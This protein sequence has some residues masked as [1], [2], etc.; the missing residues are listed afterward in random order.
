MDEP[1]LKLE[2][3]HA[4]Y[5]ATGKG[6]INVLKGISLQVARGE[7][8]TIIG[9]NGAGKTS[10][11]LVI[12]GVLRLRQG[13]IFYQGENISKI[14]AHALV[15]RGIAHVP[16]GRK[17]FTR[18]TVQENLELGAYLRK[19]KAGTASDFEKVFHLFPVL[20]ERKNQLGGTLSSGEQQMLAFARA[21]MSG[22]KLLLL[23]EPSMG[24]APLLVAK[25]FETIRELNRQGLTILVV[26]QNAH[27]ALQTAKRAY[28]LETGEITL[29]DQA[30][31]LLT[32]PRVR[33]AYL[34]G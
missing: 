31:R 33:E 16:E 12:S 34:G 3:V 1:M 29:E 28:V 20:K 18:L 11:L 25:I 8:V 13:E 17:I 22:P 30:D 23:D 5:G 19:D 4:G 32:D 9:A 10:T 15:E 24:V 7:I 21:L 26:E 6:Q 14:A 2:S 27:L